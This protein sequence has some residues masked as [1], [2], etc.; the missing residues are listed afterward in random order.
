M[1]LKALNEET[2]WKSKIQLPN[3]PK[4]LYKPST[5]CKRYYL[6]LNKDYNNMAKYYSH[7]ELFKTYN[8]YSETYWK[9]VEKR[10]LEYRKINTL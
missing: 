9:S 10:K 8:N 3:Y 6:T 2:L 4:P 7:V 1:P 5:Y